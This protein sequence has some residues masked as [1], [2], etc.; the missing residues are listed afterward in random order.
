MKFKI[1]TFFFLLVF[2]FVYQGFSQDKNQIDIINKI[3]IHESS[4]SSDSLIKL[5]STNIKEAKKN[6][7]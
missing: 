3:V 5:F 1:F 6:K 2:C 7:L 4:I